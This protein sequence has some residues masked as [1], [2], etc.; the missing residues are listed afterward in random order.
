M[1]QFIRGERAV[2]G[3]G[4]RR[5]HV[6]K[7][8]CSRARAA[9]R[10]NHYAGTVVANSYVHLGVYVDGRF[11]GALQFGYAMNPAR[12]SKVVSGTGARDYLELNRMW[13]ADWAPRN[14]ESQAISCAIHYIRAV[15][16]QVRWI[17]SFADE[18]C[19]GLGVVYQACS[20]EYIGCHSTVFYE[21]DGRW[22]HGMLRSLVKRGGSCGLFLRANV[23]RARAVKLR[24]FRY[25]YFVHRGCRRH[26]ALKRMRYPKRLNSAA[27]QSGHSGHPPESQVRS[28][29]AAPSAVVEQDKQGQ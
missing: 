4:S 29:V 15:M 16:P 14:S 27:S 5:L 12:A 23:H 9:I 10:E 6:V 25:I 19:Q 20:F 2:A 21:I 22:Y 26:L 8:P 17:Q 28:L 18:R 7:I 11:A 24:Q 1:C 13:L 3:Y